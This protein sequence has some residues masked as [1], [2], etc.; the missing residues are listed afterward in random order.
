MNL[1]LY[2]SKTN[3]KE[4]FN[5]IK[6]SHVS[7]YVCGPTIYDLIHI[8]NARSLIVFDVLY[9]LLTYLYKKVIYVRN[10]TD[11]DDKIIIKADENNQS[12]LELTTQMLHQFYKD[13]EPL[14][15]L[16]P[17][18]EPKATEYIEQMKHMIKI[19]LNNQHA[20]VKN[21]HVYFDAHSYKNYGQLSNNKEVYDN[22]QSHDKK[23]HRDWILWKPSYHQD[24]YQYILPFLT[25][26]EQEIFPL[27]QGIGWESEWGFGRPGWHLECSTMS[28]QL[29]GEQ[30]DIHGGGADLLFPH[31][32]NEIA[33]TCCVTQQSSSANYWLH[34][35]MLAIE[36]QKMSKS[37]GNI[38]T[39]RQAYQVYD[40]EV[41][42]LTLISTH[43]RQSSNYCQN[44]LQQSQNILYKWYD[45]LKQY[46]S[47]EY[48]KQSPSFAFLNAL[49]DDLNT[50]L[51]INVIH[52]DIKELQNTNKHDL[53]INIKG[54]IIAQLHLLGLLTDITKIETNHTAQLD[55]IDETL[56]NQLI[57]ERA[58]AKEAKDFATA[59]KIRDQL[60][61]MGIT[62]I[63]HADHTTSWCS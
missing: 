3:Q 25:S 40:P 32:E 37:L 36:G 60:N 8:G 6:K 28:M 43:Y 5:P 45:V 14:N 54:R 29:L 38:I 27:T 31:H 34:N 26:Q 41:I 53:I 13:I 48:Q 39:L 47:Y 9:R 17:T 11:I 1:Y 56:I 33:Q 44:T 35:G 21:Y 2:N 7:L 46:A 42:K 51:A 61:N 18:H 22:N 30:F 59:D 20:Y 23:N 49:C 15:L 12:I 57:Q 16:P 63:D 52:Q 62:L 55:T 10:I 58:R 4:L 24:N 19:L 50:P